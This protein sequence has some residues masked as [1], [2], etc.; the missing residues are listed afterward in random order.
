MI[1][2]VEN[3]TVGVAGLII[4]D[5]GIMIG[6]FKILHSPYTSLLSYEGK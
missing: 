3:L 1:L 5:K 4:I 2:I 6:K